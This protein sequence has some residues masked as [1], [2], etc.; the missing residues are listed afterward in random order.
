M[1]GMVTMTQRVGNAR[2]YG[3]NNNEVM[4]ETFIKR[5]NELNVRLAEP[6]PVN[7]EIPVPM[8]I[9]S[10]IPNSHRFRLKSAGT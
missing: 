1:P 4:V 3:S 10:S 6:K 5:P 7:K 8:K 2:L 9:S